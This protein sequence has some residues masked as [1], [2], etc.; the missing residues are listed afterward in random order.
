M[1]TLL[2]LSVA[3]IWSS[4]DL[5]APLGVAGNEFRFDA[6]GSDIL[7]RIS[8]SGREVVMEASL[9]TLPA[10]RRDAQSTMATLLRLGAG[11]AGLNPCGLCFGVPGDSCEAAG[12][13]GADAMAAL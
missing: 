7:V 11:M 8:P 6:N 4:L 1:A 9:G 13:S 12:A 5:G 2:E 10:T 3:A